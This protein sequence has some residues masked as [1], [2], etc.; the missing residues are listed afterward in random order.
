MKTINLIIVLSV[1]ILYIGCDIADTLEEKPP[2][3]IT[4]ETLYTNLDGFETGLNGLYTLVRQ[5]REG[6]SSGAQGGGN[7]LRYEL[8]ISGTDNTVA[9]TVDRFT[10]IAMNWGSVNNSQNIHLENH[11][12]WL[13]RVINSANT[14]INQAE[15]RPDVDW[16]G[17]NLNPD[18]NKN[19]VLAEAKAI[20]AWAYRHLT[21]MW[22]DVPLVVE[23]TTGATVRTDWERTP[24]DEVREHIIT[25]LIFAEEYLPVSPSV[26]GKI[27]K[28]AVQHYLSEMYLTINEPDTALHWADQVV[29]NPEYS[30]VT[31]RYGVNSDQP[32]VVFM[33]MFYDGNANRDEGNSEAL[34]VWQWDYGTS[35][36]GSNIMRR[37]LGGLY[38]EWQIDGVNPLTVT[39]ERGGRPRA[40]SLPTKWAIELY[41]PEDDR[42]SK[43]AIRKFFILKNGEENAPWSADIL[44]DGYSYG[45]TLWLNWENDITWSSDFT[46]YRDFPYTRKWD[47]GDPINPA[48]GAS[49]KD[50]VYLRLAE[51]YLLKAEAEFLLDNSA[52]AAETINIIRRR[53]NASEISP[54]DINIDF[55]LDERSRE[56]LH[57]EH[58]RYTLLRTGKWL[59]RTRMHNNNGGQFITD[60][61]RLFPIPQSVI[62]ANLTLDMPQNPG[63]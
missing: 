5:E 11:F 61:D 33:D 55:I 62:D 52:A 28:G 25:D 14:I 48:S 37:W 30:L 58:R 45:D 4:T 44:P 17:G 3:L 20:R 40:S 60:R 8:A 19:R 50:G 43:H 15:E 34:W 26:S 2:H 46:P 16:T 13:Y 42:G 7:Q 53:A 12:T 56:L 35:G 41:E 22:G 21:F 27:S 10:A 47:H 23:S 49:N 63:Y 9:N 57:E 18:D 36:G 24:V 51:T 29:N 59:E 31:E 6:E 38:Y 54:G 1:V 32:G 39:N